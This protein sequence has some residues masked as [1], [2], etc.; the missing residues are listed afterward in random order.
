MENSWL[1]ELADCSLSRTVD[2]PGSVSNG[3]VANISAL[4]SATLS[5]VLSTLDDHRA[6]PSLVNLH[7]RML[8]A[9]VVV[10]SRQCRD[11]GP[12]WS[13][14]PPAACLS[15][16]GPRSGWCGAFP[17]CGPPLHIY[18]LPP[19]LPV[20]ALNTRGSMAGWLDGRTEGWE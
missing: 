15:C 3:P 14:V 8:E 5:V 9:V 10:L 20:A 12:V 1:T 16:E 4:L 19:L 7:L 18:H 11:R 17:W 13:S 2:P 6:S